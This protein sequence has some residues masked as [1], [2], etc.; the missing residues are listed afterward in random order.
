[1]FCPKCGTQ[2]Q[3]DA[4]FCSKCGQSLKAQA[5]ENAQS[6]AQPQSTPQAQGNVK[7]ALCYVLGWISGIYFLVTEKND[8]FLRF[9]ALQSIIVFAIITVLYFVLSMFFTLALW[10]LWALIS[11]LN[12]LLGLGSLVLWALLM[13]KAYN[14]EYFKLPFVGEIAHKQ[15]NK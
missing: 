13:Y 7:G 8:R 12:T 3:D 14:N 15:V 4:G 2:N 9:H 11:M 5:P 1:M 10:R 6:A